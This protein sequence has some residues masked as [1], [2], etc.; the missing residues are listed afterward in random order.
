MEEEGRKRHELATMM[1]ADGS[2]RWSW[3]RSVLAWL[4]KQGRTIDYVPVALQNPTV[5][6]HALCETSA[7][8]HEETRCALKTHC[9]RFLTAEASPK[10]CIHEMKERWRVGLSVRPVQC[11]KLAIGLP[12]RL[13][14]LQSRTDV[15]LLDCDPRGPPFPGFL[16]CR[17]RCWQNEVGEVLGYRRKA[18]AIYYL[19][20]YLYSRVAQS[21]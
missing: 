14:R 21:V 16:P 6:G 18:G 4:R 8:E 19:L 1:N 10:S 13:F 17:S 20:I 7:S 11:L 5:T 15:D 2:V 3:H 12:N 9:V